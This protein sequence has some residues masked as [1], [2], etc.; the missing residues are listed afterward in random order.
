M[1]FQILQILLQNYRGEILQIKLIILNLLNKKNRSAE[2]TL[3]AAYYS[4]KT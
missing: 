4:A 1:I 2:E 3:K